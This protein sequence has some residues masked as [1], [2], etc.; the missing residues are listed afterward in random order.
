[1]KKEYDTNQVGK[2]ID[3]LDDDSKLTEAFALAESGRIAYVEELKGRKYVIMT[4]QKFDKL[5]EKLKAV[6]D[7]RQAE[8]EDEAGEDI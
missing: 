8:I 1:M 7:N 5:F 4:L 6:E 3:F 2:E